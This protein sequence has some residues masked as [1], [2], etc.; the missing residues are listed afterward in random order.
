[1]SEH[2]N[3]LSCAQCG[4]KLFEKACLVEDGKSLEFCPTKRM[5]GFIETAENH[6]FDPSVLEFAKQASIQESECYIN[7]EAKPHVLYPVKPRLQE[8]CEFAHRMGYKHIGLAF[9]AGLQKEASVLDKVLKQSG[10]EV[11]SVVC[12][13]GCTPKERINIVDSQKIRV[14][15]FESMCNPV[16]Q[17]EI[18]NEANTQFNVLLGLCIGHDSLF[19][20]YTK[21]PTTVFA[22]KDRVLGHNPL[23]AL[24]TIETYYQRFIK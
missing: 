13:V 21:A 7:R 19:F 8:L 22:V 12:K 3:L 6:Y 1:M 23:A 14:G 10:F 9:C 17:A 24:Y 5:K 15:E 16:V 11:S 20:K 2:N 18:L 4:I